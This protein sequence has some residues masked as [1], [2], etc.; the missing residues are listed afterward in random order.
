MLK[1]ITLGAAAGGGLPQWNCRCDNCEA[2]WHQPALHQGQVSLAVSADDGAHWFLIN[3]SPDIRAQIAATQALWPHAGRRRHSPI[4]G[5][6][7]TNG[8]IDAIAGLLSLREGQ[9]FAL[10]AHPAVLET[11]ES[12]SIFNVLNKD[13]VKRLPIT[14][15]Q[16]F[17]PTL[18]D[19]SA[20]GLIVTA[21]T[22][23]GKPA[24]YLEDSGAESAEGDTIGLTLQAKGDARA[25]HVI[26]ACAQI[27]PALRAHLKGAAM[28]F[29]E[30]TLWRD[31]EMITQGL[32]QKTGQRMGHV[33]ISGPDGSLAQLADLDIARKVFV[34]INN[35]NPVWRLDSPERAEVTTAGWEIPAPAQ[36]FEL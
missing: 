27:T 10:H 12:N 9:K 1:I 7:L 28:V 13:N 20:S 2:A 19:G 21:F 29:F 23:P 31:D 6:I 24:W 16:S 35:S 4:A 33:A 8:E 25:V 5:V 18:P 36:E 32:S 26:L 30:G 15:D 17:E 22:L 34:H 14:L 11:L 3:A